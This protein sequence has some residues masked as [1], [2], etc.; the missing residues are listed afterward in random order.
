MTQ[1]RLAHR[2]RRWSLLPV[3]LGVVYLGGWWLFALAAVAAAVALHEYWLLARPLAP[4][5]PAGLRRR[6]ARARRRR[7]RRARLDARRRALD[8]R[9]RVRPEGDLGGARR[10]RRSRSAARVMGAVWIGVGLGVPDPAA[11]A[12]RP[13]P[14]RVVHGAARGLGGRHVRLLRRPAAR[15]AQ[16]GA[17]TSPGKTWEGFVVRHG[18]D[19][20]RRVRGAL[21]AGLPDDRRSR[22]CS[23]SS[24]RRGAARRPLRVAAEARHGREGHRHAPRRP[25][26]HARPASTPSS[27]PLRPRTS[28]ILAFGHVPAPTGTGSGCSGT[29][30]P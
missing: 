3:V 23:A 18:R 8:L 19:D 15:P 21:Q 22:S 13:R 12:P 10:R 26:R 20:L 6:R 5:A 4:L 17:A 1:R 11:R 28:R 14:A 9:A 30:S 27:S 24:S 25:R 7:G 2:R 29:L 16:D